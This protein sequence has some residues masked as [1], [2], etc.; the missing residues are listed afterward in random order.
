MRKAKYFACLPRL[1]Y[2]ILTIKVQRGIELRMLALVTTG[3]G[4]DT[5]HAYLRQARCLLGQFLYDIQQ[6]QSR[7]RGHSNAHS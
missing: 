3:I 2:D 7:S 5:Q 6:F 4:I 1:F